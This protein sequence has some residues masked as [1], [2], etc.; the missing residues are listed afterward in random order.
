MSNYRILFTEGD[1]KYNVLK[2][3]G[4][5]EMRVFSEHEHEDDAKVT[6]MALEWFESLVDTGVML[7]YNVTVKESKPK[8]PKVVTQTQSPKEA[9]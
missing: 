2:D 8:K 9:E 3:I 6:L 4:N 7:N 5:N 1:S